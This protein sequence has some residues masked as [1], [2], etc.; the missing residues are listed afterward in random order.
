MMRRD[1]LAGDAISSMV[2]PDRETIEEPLVVTATS[3]LHTRGEEFLGLQQPCVW[4]K[5]VRAFCEQSSPTWPELQQTK[6]TRLAEE[7]G[8][9]SPPWNGALANGEAPHHWRVE[10][11]GRA[12]RKCT[13]TP[14]S[15]GSADFSGCFLDA[16]LPAAPVLA[17]CLSVLLF[18]LTQSKYG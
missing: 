12:L 3:Q 7:Q 4:G 2:L 11:L 1:V 13:E 17:A 5:V 10:D 14:I 15:T 8:A 6:L 18:E 9:S 16:A